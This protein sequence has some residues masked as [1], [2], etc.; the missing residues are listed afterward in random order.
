MVNRFRSWNR[1][2]LLMIRI[3][4]WTWNPNP[5]G[6][7]RN[8]RS[9]HLFWHRDYMLDH[10]SGW[11]VSINGIIYAELERSCLYALWKAW[12]G[13]RAARLDMEKWEREVEQAK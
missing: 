13:W 10:R 3:K 8:L 6:L 9:F 11:S 12:R 4:N 1:L 7:M 2:C 5:V